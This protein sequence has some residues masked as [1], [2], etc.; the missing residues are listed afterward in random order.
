[1]SENSG[2]ADYA[3]RS[4][5]QIL[6]SA[7]HKKSSAFDR[8]ECEELMYNPGTKVKRQIPRTFSRAKMQLLTAH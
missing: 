8:Q 7:V 4:G 1:M 3:A 6:N 5:Y 2:F